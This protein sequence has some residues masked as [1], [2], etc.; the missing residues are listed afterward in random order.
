MSLFLKNIIGLPLLNKQFEKK[1]FVEDFI[2]LRPEHRKL[3]KLWIIYWKIIQIQE[4]NFLFLC[5]L[6]RVVVLKGQIV[7]VFIP[8]TIHYFIHI[9]LTYIQLYIFENIKKLDN[10]RLTGTYSS[11]V[12][13]TS[14]FSWVKH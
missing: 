4:R 8:S 10:C 14:F 1:C 13:N 11:C 9:Y 5:K 2:T 6:K 7:K 12:E 3:W